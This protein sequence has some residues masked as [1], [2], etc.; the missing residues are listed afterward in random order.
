MSEELKENVVNENED[1]KVN[2]NENLE[3]AQDNTEEVVQNE[4]IET[5]VVTQEEG[6]KENEEE[7]K[8]K[9]VENPASRLEDTRLKFYSSF[10]K[11]QM[12]SLIVMVVFVALMSVSIW[13]L[14]SYG[15]Y[16]PYILI[17]VVV[18][19]VGTF[20][21][22]KKMRT[23]RTNKIKNHVS[24]YRKSINDYIYDELTSG[25][26]DMDPFGK[27]NEDNI[28]ELEIVL[29]PKYIDSNNLVHG[30][31]LNHSFQSANVV[32]YKEDG[33]NKMKSEIAFYGKVYQ[34]E[35]ETPFDDV[36]MVYLPNDNG[37][38]P[39]GIKN[40]KEV[41]NVLAEPFRVY[42]SSSNAKELLSKASKY[43]KKIEK[44]EYLIDFLMVLKGNHISF[45]FSYS[46]LLI[47]IPMKEAIVPQ[48]YDVLKEN[49]KEILDIVERI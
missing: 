2:E 31:L 45:L 22:S 13:L 15:D 7:K 1:E 19:F 10:R 38:G 5:E 21:Y 23:F 29:N 8:H 39:E 14:I 11:E 25:E 43:I 32:I 16:L 49:V 41:D 44:N 30:K 12:I 20:V 37:N 26:L 48:M 40:Y 47:D 3:E 24:D 4:S 34:F 9:K 18:V 17:G 36:T 42:S 33:E 46:D 35:V 27:L 28:K 6:L